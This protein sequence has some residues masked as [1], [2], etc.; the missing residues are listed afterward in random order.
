MRDELE[1]EM[2]TILCSCG[3]I[4]ENVDAAEDSVRT[5]VYV[6]ANLDCR[7][8]IEKSY[9][10]AGYEDICIHCGTVENL[11]MVDGFYPY[12]IDC[13]TEARVNRRGKKFTA[14]D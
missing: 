4:L 9:Y 1:V 13:S 14:K 8:L 7:S 5:N 10:S 2:E 12:C 6:R 11:V 3:S